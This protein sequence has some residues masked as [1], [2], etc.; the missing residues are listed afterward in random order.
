MKRIAIDVGGTFTDCLVMEP[1]GTVQE[2]KAPSTPADYTVGFL[3][4]LR[5]AAEGS[6][7]PLD[8]FLRDV[9]M[10]IH[11]TTVAT[12]LIV[13]REGARVGM[14]T[15]KGF[16]DIYELRGGVKLSSPYNL[17]VP[18][19]RPLVPRYLRKG[20]EE[21]VLHDGSVL[22]P[23][24]DGDVLQALEALRGEGVQAVAIC[25]LHSYANPAH[26]QRTL[27]LARERLGGV[28]VVASHE[29]LPV[30]REFE[31]FSTTVLSAYVGPA[32]ETYL[33]SLQDGLRAAGFHGPLLLV[34]NSGL[35]QTVEK[36]RRQA[37]HL[38]G[39]GPTASPGAAIHFGRRAGHRDLISIDMGGTSTDICVIKAG[40]IPRTSEN[41]IEEERVALP[42]V[43]VQS[44]GGGGGSIA[45]VDALG[46]LRVGPQ[47]AR[48]EPGP[49]CYDKG[50]SEPTITDVNV[51]LGYIDPNYFLGGEIR[52]REDLARAA[53]ERLGKQLGM[54]VVDAAK[55]SFGVMNSMIAG[56]ITTLCTKRGYDVR[57]CALVAGG[58]AGGVHGAWIAEE[59]G[60][61][62]AVVPRHAA[63]YSAF[64]MFTMQIGWEFARSY[65]VR[66]Q[67]IDLKKLNELYQELEE[68][69][70]ETLRWLKVPPRAIALTR[71]AEMRYVGQ[72]HEVETGLEGGR[73]GPASMARCLKVFH[74]KHDEL[75]AFAMPDHPIE[76]LTF[77]LRAAV[78]QPAVRLRRV[79]PGSADPSGALR[80]S[81][82]CV[83]RD[84]LVQAPVY[85]GRR[86]R[87]G[88][89]VRGPAVVEERHTTI[90]VPPTFECHLDATG[91][92]VLRR[93]RRGTRRTR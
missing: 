85:D 26:E 87:V 89:V 80:Q 92:Y 1:S 45:W 38:V 32:V 52:L 10:I 59:L 75:F 79:P 65:V 31:R 41:W 18:P 24:A 58:G 28:H 73:L 64:G 83:F 35:V 39:S 6:E 91:S 49:A 3:D 17:F 77:R 93:M 27:D 72:Y 48:A 56:Y 30:W 46:V 37:V 44:F 9:E 86:L 20:V 51:V 61:D 11:G 68:E 62:V 21:R 36:C 90:V 82:A 55:A 57:D 60:I 88:N 81:R 54:G 5:K 42:M 16:R 7:Q 8:V 40:A 66:A 69:A 19:Y 23:L 84:R 4:A 22:T 70:R 50:G 13:T 74:R 14:I 12:N 71:T 15:T 34:V 33:G 47:S 25:Y 29:V 2:F 43:N 76:F 63:A 67:G 53:L 78:A